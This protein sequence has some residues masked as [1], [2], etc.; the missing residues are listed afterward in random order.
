MMTIT[1]KKWSEFQHYKP[2]TRNIT[3][4][5]LHKKLLDDPEWAGLD[6]QAAKV[7]VMLWLLASERNG[8]LPDTPEIAFRLRLPKTSI[9]S[10]LS[11][12]S[13]WLEQDASKMLAGGYQ[14]AS[15]VASLYKE[16]EKE[17]EEEEEK[18]TI[19]CRAVK[20]LEFL[21]A[22]THKNFKAYLGANGHETPTKSLELVMAR[23]KEGY[24][25][26]DLKGMIAMKARKWGPDPKMC[27]FLRPSTLFGKEKCEM[28]VGEQEGEH[29]G[30][31]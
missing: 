15:K 29:H 10:A 16:E 14:D 17:E 30:M 5:K 8:Q 23:L 18:E 12:L 24:T 11:K 7:L 1:I 19:R 2:E 9:E 26:D 4:I 20:L 21:N 22:K 6:P 27:E 3:W 25:D 28:Y 31:S 13:H